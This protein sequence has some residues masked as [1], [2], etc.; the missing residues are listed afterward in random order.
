MDISSIL[1]L[2]SFGLNL[3]GNIS[4]RNAYRRQENSYVQ[5]AELNQRIG[6]FNAEIAER[7][8]SESMYAILE[9]TKRLM[10]KQ[11]VEFGNRGIDLEGS[12]MLVI[13]ETATM[14]A[15]EAQSAYFN[16]QVQKVNYKLGAQNAVNTA[17]NGA[18]N[19]KYGAMSSML[20]TARGVMQGLNLMN[21][22]MKSSTLNN[23]SHSQG[24]STSN[25]TLG[26]IVESR[27][28]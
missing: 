26:A 7:A 25:S 6:Q 4:S 2:G 28:K 13:G 16:A 5:Q 19:A 9:N 8:G 22:M 14:G 11:I 1:S 12:P 18:E 21:S 10:G 24:V 20:N 3:F 15:A 27:F 23:I 17:L